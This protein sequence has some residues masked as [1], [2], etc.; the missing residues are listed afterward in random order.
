[1]PWTKT[2]RIDVEG[3]EKELVELK[4]WLSREKSAWQAQGKR[5]RQTHVCISWMDVCVCFSL[6]TQFLCCSYILRSMH[7][8]IH[9]FVVRVFFWCEEVVLCSVTFWW[10]SC[11]CNC[12]MFFI[13]TR[14]GSPHNIL[15]SYQFLLCIANLLLVFPPLNVCELNLADEGCST[16]CRAD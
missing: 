16:F 8:L 12:S 11:A 3:K 10:Q 6:S 15:H 5:Q 14:S 9:V 13:C 4:K 1:M 7:C 2:W